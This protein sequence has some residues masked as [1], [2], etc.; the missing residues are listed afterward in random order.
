MYCFLYLVLCSTLILA[1]LTPDI[2]FSLTNHFFHLLHTKVQVFNLFSLL[3]GFLLSHFLLRY[4]RVTCVGPN[5]SSLSLLGTTFFSFWFTLLLSKSNISF[6]SSKSFSSKSY[7][8]YIH[9]IMEGF[10]FSFFIQILLFVLFNNFLFLLLLYEALIV[11]LRY[12]RIFPFGQYE[13]KVLYDKNLLCW[14]PL[15]SLQISLFS[16]SSFSSEGLHLHSKVSQ[17]SSPTEP[18]SLLITSIWYSAV[19]K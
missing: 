6:G 12:F 5:M 11:N 14:W 15:D 17:T 9:P 1:V 3:C 10:L 19:L 13:Q 2:I 8:L 16:S 7:T 4:H 18:S